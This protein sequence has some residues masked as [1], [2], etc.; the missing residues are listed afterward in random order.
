MECPLSSGGENC[1]LLLWRCASP[2]RPQHMKRGHMK[3]GPSVFIC[4]R[5]CSKKW[6]NLYQTLSSKNRISV[7]RVRSANLLTAFT[8]KGEVHAGGANIWNSRRVEDSPR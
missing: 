2:L 5:R 6:P 7:R 4:V 8:E 3:R 1:H